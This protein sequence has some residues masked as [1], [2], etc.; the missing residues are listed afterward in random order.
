MNSLAIFRFVLIM[1][2][3]GRCQAGYGR[4]RED[5]FQ[6]KACGEI[7]WLSWVTYVVKPLGIYLVSLWT[8]HKKRDRTAS[9]L[10]IWMAFGIVMASISPSI[11]SSD[12]FAKIH[13]SLVQSVEA[14]LEAFSMKLQYVAVRILELPKRFA[15]FFQYMYIY[16]RYNC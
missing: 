12:T 6:C 2:S 15:P 4:R 3:V 11:K 5:P 16:Y 14:G 13:T 8:A 7:P 1:R 10:K 9:L